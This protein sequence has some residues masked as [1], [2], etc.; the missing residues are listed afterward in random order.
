[1]TRAASLSPFCIRLAATTDEHP[2]YVSVGRTFEGGHETVT[3][4]QYEFARGDVTTNTVEGFFSLVKRSLN[5]IYHAVSKEHLHRYMAEIEFRYNNRK[6]EDGERI[7]AAIRAS[8]GK[9]LFYK[10]PANAA[11]PA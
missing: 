3:H 4:S 9:R 5:G 1:M 7:Q 8:E 11:V 6:L 2:S 10:E